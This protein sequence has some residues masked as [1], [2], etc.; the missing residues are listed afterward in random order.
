MNIFDLVAGALGVFL[1]GVV[2]VAIFDQV[3]VDLVLVEVELAVP[4]GLTFTI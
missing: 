4:V 2:D 1:R 3:L